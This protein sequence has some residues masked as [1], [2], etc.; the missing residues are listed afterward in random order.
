M[1]T[2]VE[3]LQVCFVAASRLLHAVASA[4]TIHF[5]SHDPDP[6]GSSLRAAYDECL[7]EPV[8]ASIDEL[9]GKLD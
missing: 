1:M 5:S 8:P 6:I 9:L 7:S 2:A 3:G 4:D